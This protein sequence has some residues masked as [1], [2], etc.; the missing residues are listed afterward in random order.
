MAATGGGSGNPVTFTVDPSASSVCSIAGSTVSFTA[1]GTCKVNA[2]QAG[3]ANYEPAAQVQQSFAVAKGDQA[4]VFTSTAPSGAKVGGSTYAVAATGG[5]SGNPVTFTVDPSASSVCS[6]AGSTVSFTAVGTCKVNA[7]QAGNAN[8][9]P[10]AQVQ[11]SFAVAK[12]DQTVSF[13]ALA[14]KRF[15]ESPVTMSATASSGLAVSFSSATPGVC[16][17]AGA[18]V[19]FVSVGTCTVN[20]NQA[21]SSNWNAAP[22]VQQSFQVTKGN[23]TISFAALADRRFDESPITVGATASSGS[24]VAF[25]SATPGV[26]SVTGTSV[27]FVSVGTCTVNANQAGS[28]NWNAAPQVQ[29]SFQVLKGNQAISF[30]ALADKRFDESLDGCGDRELRPDGEL[31]LGDA[32][33]LHDRRRGRRVDRVREHRHLH[34]QRRPGR[35]R[36]L[37]RRRRR[38]SA[39]SR[40]LKGNQAIS[41]A[42]LADKRLDESL[43]G[44]GD[45]DLRSD[46]ELHLGDPGCLLG[47][48]DE[49]DV[50]LG[51]HLHGERG[52]GREREL[53]PGA[54]GA[55]LVPGDE[56]EPDD[57]LHVDRAAGRDRGRRALHRNGDGQLGPRRDLRHGKPRGLRV[58][59]HERRHLQLHRRRHLHR[60][61]HAARAT[62]TGTP[63]RR[64]RS[65]SPSARQAPRCP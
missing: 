65:P 37:E 31:H 40:S 46:G 17:I 22:Q 52:P 54:A 29:Q 8:Y 59:R 7:N 2:N 4:I 9:E 33:G 51:R 24:A 3:N 25:S 15:D 27:T 28:S 48:G 58:G 45:R 1:V 21:G 63:P 23:Q 16:T 53:E 61:R 47:R 49:R 34:G 26:C 10:A 57:R 60:E 13:G 5:G 35:E 18:S 64:L 30:A 39:R 12:G 56:G 19:S 43:H 32:G 62:R 6:I 38:C 44:R 20:A 14:D 42:A 36:E 11:Q 50:R 55:A 41:F